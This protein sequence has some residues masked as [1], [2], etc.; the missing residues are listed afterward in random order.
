MSH[1]GCP[2]IPSGAGTPLLSSPPT[3]ARRGPT[4]SRPDVVVG[5]VNE[6]GTVSR[7]TTRGW[8]P[9]TI[10]EWNAQP[11]GT[12]CTHR[13]HPLAKRRPHLDRWGRS[14]FACAT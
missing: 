8:L 13:P 7:G 14:S 3:R 9:E 2:P 12:R 5:P 1:T 4:C 10:D 11:G 6:D